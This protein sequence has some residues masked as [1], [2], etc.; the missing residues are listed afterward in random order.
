MPM[1]V[2]LDTPLPKEAQLNWSKEL[3]SRLWSMT[4]LWLACFW[5]VAW[6]GVGL[7]PPP[8]MLS[9]KWLLG[10]HRKTGK[11]KVEDHCQQHNKQKQSCFEGLVDFPG[12]IL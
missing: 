12:M 8:P 11:V 3:E 2:T 1:I 7:D 6:M 4:R 10:M 9:P 5:E